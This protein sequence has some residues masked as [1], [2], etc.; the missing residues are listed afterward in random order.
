MIPH[1]L[2]GHYGYGYHHAIPHLF[3]LG[4][5]YLIS[6][7][8][9]VDSKS[10]VGYPHWLIPTLLGISTSIVVYPNIIVDTNHSPYK[11]RSQLNEL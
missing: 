10:G 4:H 1:Q 6:G 7:L 8:V 11:L 9:I 5:H 3:L 2:I